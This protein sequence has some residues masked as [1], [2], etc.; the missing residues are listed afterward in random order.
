MAMQ[1]PY[2]G[3]NPSV[4]NEFKLKGNQCFAEGDFWN[5]LI[6]YNKALCRAVPGSEAIGII[7]ACRSVL[8]F[9]MG[10]FPNCLNNMQLARENNIPDNILLELLTYEE[11]CLE[12][13]SSMT[14]L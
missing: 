3:K 12:L 5:A 9:E 10:F 11:K 13:M 4:A 1:L 6:F 8:C 2:N 7:Y 14:T